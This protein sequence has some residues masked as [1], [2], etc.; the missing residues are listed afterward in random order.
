[1]AWPRTLHGGF[2]IEVDETAETLQEITRIN[3]SNYLL[4]SEC[5]ERGLKFGHTIELVVLQV[6]SLLPNNAHVKRI[7]NS[8]YLE[9]LQPKWSTCFTQVRQSQLKSMMGMCQ[10]SLTKKNCMLCHEQWIISW[11]AW[12]STPLADVVDAISDVLFRPW[13]SKITC[14][15]HEPV[16]W[17][18]TCQAGSVVLKATCQQ[19]SRSKISSWC[20]HLFIQFLN[21]QLNWVIIPTTTTQ[22]GR[23]MPHAMEI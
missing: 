1:M 14:I 6:R 3:L 23:D 16:L 19:T 7:N 18:L 11:S 2:E 22:T 8:V 17:S 13:S 5:H 15:A 20:G 12:P 4:Y 21:I 9:W 10:G